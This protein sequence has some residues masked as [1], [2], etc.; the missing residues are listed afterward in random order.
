MRDGVEG[1]KKKNDT[2]REAPKVGPF[3]TTLV[4]NKKMVKFMIKQ[5]V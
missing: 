1:V 4:I 5:Q 3:T 2:K